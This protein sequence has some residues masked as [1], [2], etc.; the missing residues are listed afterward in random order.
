VPRL[1]HLNGPPGIGKSTLSA[2]YVERH[3]GTLN[4]DI[5]TL[6]RLVG[7]WRETDGRTHEILRPVALAMATAHLTGG[8]DVVLPQYLGRLDAVATFEGAALAAGASFREVV[9]L[10][11][12][13]GSI[14]RFHARRD[15]TPWGV[16][17]REQVAG[18]GGTR[19]LATMYD[20]LLDV[21]EQRPSAVVVRSEP[22]A[23]ERTYDALV[24][25]L[26]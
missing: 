25:A 20:R 24:E 5:D 16:H 15:D 6:H 4:L 13:A 22:G 9:L 7:G 21:L 26:D 12:K 23:V 1:I 17:V 19:A 3:P 10:D 2:L 14:A 8:R 18:M 11:E